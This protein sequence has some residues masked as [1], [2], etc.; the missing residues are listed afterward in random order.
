MAQRSTPTPATDDT[1]L[2]DA[3]SQAVTSG[4]ERVAPAVA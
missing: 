1:A 2:L 4:V 3:Y